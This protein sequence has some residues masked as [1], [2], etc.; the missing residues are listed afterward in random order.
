MITKFQN[1]RLITE[2]PDKVN[3]HGD[4]EGEYVEYTDDDALPFFC[5]VNSDHTEVENV[6]IVDD[7][8]V[9]NVLFK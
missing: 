5:T 4:K 7:V 2:S 1:Y 9:D 8:G 3:L 6:Y